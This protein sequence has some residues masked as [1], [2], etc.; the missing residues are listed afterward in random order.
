MDAL[1]EGCGA[2]TGDL[3]K[4]SYG[5]Y[6][7]LVLEES[8]DCVTLV[9]ADVDMGVLLLRLSLLRAVDWRVSS[10]TKE[11]RGLEL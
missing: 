6:A 7:Q 1:A 2:A 9:G 8:S 3:L 11:Y 10:R 4:T 5:P